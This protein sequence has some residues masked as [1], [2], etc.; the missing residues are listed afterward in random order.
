MFAVFLAVYFVVGVA[1][2]QALAI[3]M[4]DGD[5]MGDSPAPMLGGLFWPLAG[6]YFIVIGAVNKSHKKLVERRAKKLLPEAR[7]V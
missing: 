2:A 4:N 1:T 6:P 7:V 5:I 3:K